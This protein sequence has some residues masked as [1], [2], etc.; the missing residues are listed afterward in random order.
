M[1]DHPPPADLPVADKKAQARLKKE[2]QAKNDIRRIVQGPLAAGVFKLG[3]PLSIAMLLQ[4]MFN[5]V[6]MAIVGQIPMVAADA[7]AALIICD[8]VAMIPTI[9]GN[10]ISNA[11]AALIAR[12]AGE[13]DNEGAAFFCWQSISLTLALSVVFG[14]IG[15]LGSDF[16]VHDIFQAKGELAILTASYMPVIIGGCFSILLLL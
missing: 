16:I 7:I 11:S 3:F 4:S 12:R 15:I 5:L 9:L 13:G 2:Q 8:L 6:D 10:G 1:N 14:V